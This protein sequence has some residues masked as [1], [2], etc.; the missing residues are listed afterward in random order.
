MH[1]LLVSLEASQVVSVGKCSDL[2]FFFFILREFSADEMLFVCSRVWLCGSPSEG[3][4]VSLY[5]LTL[6]FGPVSKTT[7][8]LK[9]DYSHCTAHFQPMSF[10]FTFEQVTERLFP[11]PVTTSYN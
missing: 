6:V 7:Y 4:P 5:W 10:G 3:M 11:Q 9:S 8:I 1:L 2:L